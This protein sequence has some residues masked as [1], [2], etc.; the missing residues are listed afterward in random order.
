MDI[1]HKESKP[2]EC[3]CNKLHKYVGLVVFGCLCRLAKLGATFV[4]RRGC[5]T[6]RSHCGEGNNVALS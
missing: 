6:V 2:T 4:Q 5:G 1:L 3:D